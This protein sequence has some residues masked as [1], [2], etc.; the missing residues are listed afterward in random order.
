MQQL[1]L[2]SLTV[3]Q[4]ALTVRALLGKPM[5]LLLALAINL[6]HGCSH[7][8]TAAWAHRPDAAPFSPASLLLLQ[9]CCSCCCCYHA[10]MEAWGHGSI[11]KTLQNS[12]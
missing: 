12:C 1:Q 11:S 6:L 10:S 7:S 8:K 4:L 9:R 3:S 5:L 2:H